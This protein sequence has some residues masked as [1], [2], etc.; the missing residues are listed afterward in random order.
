MKIKKSERGLT[1]ALPEGSVN[2]GEKYRYVVDVEKKEVVIYPDANGNITASRKKSGKG[3]KP[4]FD[5]RSREV[6]SLCSK[7]DYI[8]VE[9]HGN[10][11]I[12]HSYQKVHKTF[13]LIKNNIVSI[14]DVLC[15]ESG[16]IILSTAA[17]IEGQMSLFDIPGFETESTRTFSSPSW[18]TKKE[19]LQKVY[20]VVSLFSGAGL[21][22]YSFRDPQF[23]FIYGID[24]DKDACAT[25]RQN[26]GDHIEC[27]D[28]R[29]VSGKEIPDAN[30]IIGG[31]CCQGYSNANRQD[32]SEESAKVKRL[33]IDD[34]IRL[35][36]DK[37]PEVFVIENV[38]QL[39]TKEDGIYIKKVFERL[40]NYQITASVISD[41]MVGGYTIRKRAIVIG[42]RIG[43]IKLPDAT[44]HT[45]KT[46]RDALSKVD[47]SWYNFSDISVQSDK[48]K[49]CMSYVRPGHNWK[50]IPE[51]VAVFKPTTHSDRYYRLN[52]DKPSPTIVNWRKI[53]MMPPTG[54]RILSVAEAAAL[55]G[56]DKNFHVLGSNLGAK[57][58][59]I[60]NGVTQAIGNFV[61]KNIL[62]ALNTHF[63]ITVCAANA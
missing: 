62:N 53:C 12:V 63:T 30:L 1:F 16:Q 50:D 2:I 9:I 56:L 44:I 4:L 47:S 57:Q 40:P 35:V 59:Q 10:Q 14:E 22:D 37:N 60:G 61:K 41:D 20:D 3:F 38:P 23:R 46:V 17:G 51:S 55:M 58:Q 36:N 21:L 43:E 48:T 7:A 42:S 54:N 19:D 24:F 26:I 45:V 18:F 52:P 29:D 33:L 39:L 5:I 27:R 15:K 11:I 8:E 25:Y 32:I 28:I 13:H 34:Y 49:E 31:P 6:R